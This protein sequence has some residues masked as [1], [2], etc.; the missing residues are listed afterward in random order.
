VRKVLESAL[1][2]QP[3]EGFTVNQ[4]QELAGKVADYYHAK[5]F[6][7]AQAFVPAQDVR[8]GNVTVQ[9]LEGK[10]SAIN[11]EGNKS[12]S[13]RSLLRPFR[14]L[15]GGPVEKDSIESALLTLTNYPGVSAFGVLGAGHD[16]GTTLLTLRVQSE[17]R[18]T[19]ESS[20]DNHG[21]QFAGQ[22]RGQLALGFN[23]LLGDADRL[24]LYGLYGLTRA[25]AKR[26][27]PM[28]ELLTRFPYSVHGIRC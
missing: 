3:P 15:L 14:S 18:V 19:V 1:Q 7:L 11:V 16:I 25:T 22:Y 13:T 6:I 5:G 4:L 8:D 23:N 12:Y 26:T 10:L 20:V 2:Q 9:V 21:S 17:K 28:V 27:A 24:R